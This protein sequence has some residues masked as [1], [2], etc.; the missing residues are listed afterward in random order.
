M[1]RDRV[2]DADRIPLPGKHDDLPFVE[3]GHGGIERAINVLRKKL[4]KAG[5]FRL[6]KERKNFPAPG[7]RARHKAIMSET[8]RRREQA[9]RGKA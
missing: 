4:G 1:E 3:V 5:T 6:L 9:K 7:D 2:T 8:R